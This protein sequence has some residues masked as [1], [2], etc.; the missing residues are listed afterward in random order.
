MTGYGNLITHF[1]WLELLSMINQ[2]LIFY[3][4]SL[5]VTPLK[6]KLKYLLLEI[7][8]FDVGSNNYIRILSTSWK[9]N[10][11]LVM[12]SISLLCMMF[13]LEPCTLP[14]ENGK[15]WVSIFYGAGHLFGWGKIGMAPARFIFIFLRPNLDSILLRWKKSGFENLALR[16]S[17]P[18]PD[19]DIWNIEKVAPKWRFLV[20]LLQ[21]RQQI[22]E[23]FGI[24]L[25]MVLIIQFTIHNSFFLLSIQFIGILK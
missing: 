16:I 2:E 10:I 15:I 25:A 23:W 7:S 18:W 17:A 19:N 21:K 20:T 22:S 13:W 9:I 4:G 3:F 8:S 12:I 6:W 24:A 1:E 11:Q 14:S 5:G